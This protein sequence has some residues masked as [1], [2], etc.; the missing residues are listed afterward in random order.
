MDKLTYYRNG[1]LLPS[2]GFK[3]I[4]DHFPSIGI[5]CQGVF[6]PGLMLGEVMTSTPFTHLNIAGDKLSYEKLSMTVAIDEDM[7]IY[8]EV[9]QWIKGIA[10]PEGFH[11]YGKTRLKENIKEPT[12]D[13]IYSDI[14]V[15]LLNNKGIPNIKFVFKDAYPIIIGGVQLSTT[16][17]DDAHETTEISFAFTGYT[18]EKINETEELV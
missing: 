12:Y 6:I 13:P 17:S 11:Q 8:R 5:L 1:N 3:V 9:N 16:S 10:F 7:E 4:I 15:I 2:D 14:T 18:I